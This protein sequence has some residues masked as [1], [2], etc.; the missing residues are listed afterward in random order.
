[1]TA[2]DKKT[3]KRDVNK[4]FNECLKKATPEQKKEMQLVAIG[5]LTAVQQKAG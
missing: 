3:A 2:Q 5:F 1:M 4:L